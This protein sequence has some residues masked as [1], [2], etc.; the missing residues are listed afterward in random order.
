MSGL[1]ALEGDELLLAEALERFCARERVRERAQ[2]SQGKHVPGLWKALCEQGSLELARPDAGSVRLVVVTMEVL[3]RHG[4]P[5]PLSD[6][7]LAL[8]LVDDDEAAPLLA[9]TGLASIATPPLVPEGAR[10]TLLLEIEHDS[11]FRLVR[12]GEL[13]P[14]EGLAAEAWGEGPVSRVARF[15]S[16]AQ[17]LLVHDVALSAQLAALADG[18]VR[19]TAEHAATRKQFGKPIAAFQAVSHPL[20]SAHITLS[21]ASMLAR[22]AA[23]AADDANLVRARS[24]A[25]AALISAERAALEAVYT[26]H[27]KLGA[28][29]ITLEG[30]AHHVS[31]RVRSLSTRAA[32]RA[33]STREQLLEAAGVEVGGPRP[34]SRPPL[35]GALS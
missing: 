34:R 5:G 27:Q 30:P 33:E 25:T 14:R 7:I 28:L 9:G 29:G 17:A 18:L 19:R 3:G 4:L 13:A 1:G 26:C 32:S 31:R 35:S 12:R 16:S 10:A 11:V 2:E 6:T 24:L 15:E 20:A 23:C 8:G 21:A 22:A